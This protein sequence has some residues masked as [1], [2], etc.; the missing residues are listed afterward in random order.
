VISEVGISLILLVGAGLLVRSFERLMRVD[1]GFDPKRLLTFVVAL[2]PTTQPQQQN[3]FYQ[4]VVQRLQSEPGVHSAAAV[5]RLPLSGGNSTRSFTLVPKS[6]L[7][8]FGDIRVVTPEY[9]GTMGIPLLKGRN[10]TQADNSAAALVAVVNEALAQKTFPG[11]D[12]IGKY[13]YDF[14][15]DSQSLQIVGVVG[16]IRHVSLADA[17]RPEIYQPLGQA[18]WPSMFMV[19]RSKT[20]KPAALMSA[21][22]NAVWNVNRDVPLARVRTM[23]DV[24]GESVQRRTFAMLLLA[25]F[26]GLAML[27]AAIGLYGVMSYSVSQRTREIGVRMALGAQRVD[28]LKLVVR[29]GMILVGAGLG[30]G[31]VA[32]LAMT[33]LMSGLLF[34]ISARD[35][36]TFGIVAGLLTVVALAASYLPARRATKVD[37][38]IALRYE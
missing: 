19:V 29:Q 27:L 21:A 12:P 25:I 34:G 15:P 26:A 17:P 33:G 23:E 8:Y 20:D 30:M 18:G 14:G 6:Q 36:V 35:P 1:P 16:D 31:I 10:F 4:Q 32:S 37:P 2:P 9:F 7:S 11:Q 24:I 38:M 22:Q 13:L 5:S 28:V 3:A